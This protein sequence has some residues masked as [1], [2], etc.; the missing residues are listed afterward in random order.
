MDKSVEKTVALFRKSYAGGL[1]AEERAEMARLLEDEGMRRLYEEMGDDE[2]LTGE[3][4]RYAAWEPARG[5]RKFRKRMQRQSI[6]RSIIRLSVAASLLIALGAVWLLAERD[7]PEDSVKMAETAVEPGTCR[8]FLQLSSGERIVLEKSG[9]RDLHE[10]AGNIRIDSG[11]V[12]YSAPVASQSETVVYNILSV[13]NGGEYHLLLADGSAVH[14]NA[15]SEL[16]YPVA[17]AAAERK[18][19]LKGEAWFE[20]AKDAERPFYVETD[21][22]SIRVYGT[23]F[24]VNTHGLRATE[25]VLVKGEI[26][27]S[28]KGSAGERRMRPGQLAACDHHSGEITFREVDVRKYS[29]WKN[30]EFC[31]ND[32]TLEEILEELGRW[33]DVRIVYRSA[34]KKHIQFSGHLKRYENIRKILGAISES[35]GIVFQVGDRMI[36]VE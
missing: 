14:L 23:A 21:E 20:V 10:T 26:G 9:Q 19:Q 15:G 11:K 30:G 33:Y 5:Y 31:F 13:P 29:A 12:V 16:R 34:G 35:T 4:R 17:F 18:V 27:I 7:R 32:D 2:Y 3:F 28:G 8:A 36:V 1:T 22:V 6:Q 24:N 25:T